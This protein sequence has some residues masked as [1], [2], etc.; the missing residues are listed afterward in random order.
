MRSVS[1]NVTIDVN[2]ECI[3]DSSYLIFSKSLYSQKFLLI[4]RIFVSLNLCLMRHDN[5]TDLIKRLK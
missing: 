5:Q 3:L 4:G 1:H 2:G